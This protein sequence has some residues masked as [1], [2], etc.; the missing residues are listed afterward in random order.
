MV[1][2]EAI[3]ELAEKLATSLAGRD[4]VIAVAESLTGGQLAADLARAPDASDW[5]AGGVVAYSPAA[6]Q[7]VLGVPVGPVVSSVAASAM[8]A[9]VARLLGADIAVAVTGVGGPDEL[10]G[11]PPGTVWFG[12][13]AHDTTEAQLERFA[14]EPDDIVT[15]TRATALRLLIERI[16]A[17]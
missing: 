11:Q 12:I 8:A 17:S 6:K 9:G 3:A 16:V 5:F 14:G 7:S 2:G 15:A 10:E 4:L 13:H 1:D